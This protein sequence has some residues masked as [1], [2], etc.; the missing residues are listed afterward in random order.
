MI[1][2]N[3]SNELSVMVTDPGIMYPIVFHIG[4]VKEIAHHLHA[5]K[6]MFFITIFFLNFLILVIS[7]YK[8]FDHCYINMLT[9]YIA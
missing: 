1:L 4:Q 5:E 8:K 3:L 2:R 6:K 7:Y 9:S